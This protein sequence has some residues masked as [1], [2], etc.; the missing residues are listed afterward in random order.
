MRRRW[1]IALSLCAV[2]AVQARAG[3]AKVHTVG[4]DGLKIESKI[5]ADDP[6][7]KVTE[8]NVNVSVD[9]PAKTFL[10]KLTNGAKYR[11]D[12]IGPD[13]DPVLAIQDGT[14]K[15]IAFDD[16][17]GEGLNSRL[18]FVA[19]A[20]ATYKFVCASLK[21]TGNITLT[22]KQTATGKT[23]T[24]DGGA[25]S[26]KEVKFEGQ[27]ANSD[28]TIKLGNREFHGKP[29][30]VKMAAGKKYQ[31]DMVKK[32]G[33]I[34]PLLF[35][36]DKTGKVLAVD[37]DGGGFPNARIIFPCVKDD[38]YKL[39]AAALTGEGGYTLTIK[40]VGL[41]GQE[42]KVHEVGAGGLKIEGKLNKDVRSIIYQVKME[43]D[44][45]YVI[46]MISPDQKALDPF[47]KLLDSSGKQL[48]EDDD[49]GEGL[50]AR[51]TFRAPAAGTYRIIAT[52]FGNIGNGDFTL[53]VRQQQ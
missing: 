32:D 33:S 3:G 1:M 24:G 15:Q 37:D 47:L 49:G 5:D 18:D 20:D 4:K 23:G 10:I 17:G 26:G 43:A 12:L 50:N 9:L 40:E 42:A 48:A 11:I 28:P 7:I 51:I 2:M 25:A 45:N 6:K 46:D 38:T 27:V 35:L 19:P 36:Q 41:T 8:P 21:G 29:H 16:D 34:D 53:E 44:K 30:E 14:G 52:S 13:L 39:F 22:V 31:L